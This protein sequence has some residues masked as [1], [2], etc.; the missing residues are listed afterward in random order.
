MWLTDSVVITAGPDYI[1]IDPA[2]SG[3]VRIQPGEVLDLLRA[4][5]HAAI[6]QVG[7]HDPKPDAWATCACGHSAMQ[8][9]R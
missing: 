6:W 2:G 9:W 7:R 4:L 3:S 8:H 1:Q 5:S